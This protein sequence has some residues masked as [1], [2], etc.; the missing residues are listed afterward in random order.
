M[1]RLVLRRAIDEHFNESEL[2]GLCFELGIDF[3]HLDGNNKADKVR[4][5]ILYCERHRRLDELVEAIVRLRPTL[6][7]PTV[8]ALDRNGK[9]SV[10]VDQPRHRFF[11]P[12]MNAGSAA[13]TTSRLPSPV[14]IAATAIILVVAAVALSS[15][16]SRQ[17]G[18]EGITS[19]LDGSTNT[20]GNDHQTP[21]RFVEAGEFIM[22]ADE[23]PT[24]YQPARTVYLDGYWIDTYEVTNSNYLKFVDDTNHRSPDHWPDGE[25]SPG[26]E[27][28]PVLAVTW[29]DAQQYCEWQGGKRLP[30]EAEWEKASRGVD[31]RRW[32]WGN[33]GIEGWA[34]TVEAGENFT[35]PIGSFP[36]DVSPYGVWDMAGNAQEWVSDWYSPEYYASAV[37]Q[38][39]PG[40]ISGETKVVRGGA[41]WLTMEQSVT[42][43]RLGIFPPDFPPPINEESASP[44]STIGFRCACAGCQ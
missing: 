34:N 40:P 35:K 44:A 5:L 9:D 11:S 37:T 36:K 38:N 21:M 12:E 17:D 4:A 8:S 16:R 29:Y 41:F 13:Q 23:S 31:G 39:P 2:K 10:T 30:T 26:Q 1:D 22:G 43:G 14:F 20:S 6:G 15:L 32:P 24:D 19:A 18:T 7:D 42:Y 27:D 25:F 3:E 33:S 28:H